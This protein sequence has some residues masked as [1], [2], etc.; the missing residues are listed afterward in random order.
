MLWTTIF[1]PF[2]VREWDSGIELVTS[3][4]TED[5]RV[6]SSSP[7]GVNNFLIFSSLKLALTTT[8]ISGT[9]R[10]EREANRSSPTSAMVKKTHSP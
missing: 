3:S 10:Q 1:E 4:G 5:R 8:R 6:R 9:K 7:C 2:Q